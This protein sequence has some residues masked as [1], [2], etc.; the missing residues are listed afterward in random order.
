M[1]R[2]KFMHN[3]A[4]LDCMRLKSIASLRL[5]K[6]DSNLHC[7]AS[8]SAPGC[9]KV[10][11]GISEPSHIPPVMPECSSGTFPYS[12]TAVICMAGWAGATEKMNVPVW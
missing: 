8:S 11:S 10:L 2:F 9:L 3:N 7:N 12:N 5:D 1:L 4:A 6:L